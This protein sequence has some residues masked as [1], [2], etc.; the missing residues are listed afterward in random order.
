[1]QLFL[2]RQ[3]SDND[4]FQR[5]AEDDLHMRRTCDELLINRHEANDDERD[6]AS[7]LEVA[8]EGEL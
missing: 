7:E 4:A 2:R 8:G 5:R 3:A 6:L 1:M